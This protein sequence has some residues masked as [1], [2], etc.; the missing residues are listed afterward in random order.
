MTSS[1]IYVDHFTD[2]RYCD[3]ESAE[4]VDCTFYG[5]VEVHFDPEIFAQWWECP[6][7]GHEHDEGMGEEYYE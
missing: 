7:C 2:T 6:L 3:V 1:G 4:G 5:E